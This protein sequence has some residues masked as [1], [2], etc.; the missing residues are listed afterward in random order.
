M[1]SFLV[2]LGTIGFRATELSYLRFWYF[3]ESLFDT[4]SGYGRNPSHPE[5]GSKYQPIRKIN[6]ATISNRNFLSST[7]TWQ[8]IQEQNEFNSDDQRLHPRNLSGRFSNICSS[9][10]GSERHLASISLKHLHSLWRFLCKVY[11]R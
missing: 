10:I 4:I 5:W 11:H 8:R 6:E 2:H 3:F 9:L 1:P 7:L